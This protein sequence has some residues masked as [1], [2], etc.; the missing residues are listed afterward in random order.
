LGLVSPLGKSEDETWKAMLEGRSGAGPIK[1][2]DPSKLD[3]RFA[4]E[5]KDF[6]PLVYMDR[7]EAK[8]AD[9]FAQYGIAAADQ[10]LSNAGYDGTQVPADRTGVLI[11]SGIGGIGTFEEQCKIYL[12]KGPQR[13]SPF[14]VPMF[15]PDM[16]SGLVSIRV[17]A[18][19]PNYCTV[20]A[21]ASSAHAIGEA[22]Q[23]IKRGVVDVMVAGGAEAA[24]TPL[25]VS[26]FANMKALSPWNDKPQQASRPFDKDRN[27]F[28]LGDGSGIVILEALEHAL[29]RGATIRGEV[30]GYGM[31]G[32]AHHMTQPAPGGE[33]A[34]RA[35]RA[36]LEDANLDPS[37]IGYI[38]AH[39]T[40]TPQGDIA[41]VIAVKE[42]LGDAASKLIMASTKSM[43]GH[44]LGAAGGLEFSV[45]V[46]VLE[47][48]VIPPTINYE[49]PDPEC[50]LDCAPNT[51]VE[52]D[53]EV[54]IS[55]SF[56][57]GG[58][59]VTVAV[60]RYRE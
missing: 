23:L 35:M 5:V 22:S 16:A 51:S 30:I 6:D 15:I 3:V 47:T 57:F 24:I 40:S 32:D 7:K 29:D 59:N 58:H 49:T 48:G 19:G 31:S 11:G 42:V 52:R 54:A 37:E 46:K 25:S 33:G 56:G 26:G 13:V 18:R 28:V 60:R 1:R 4:C 36:C 2:F 55:N 38:N 8:R 44:L 14:F 53:V 10:A 34:M 41:E 50:D 39:G 27:G 17:G 20:S 43:T 12:T 21:C 45:C 9:L